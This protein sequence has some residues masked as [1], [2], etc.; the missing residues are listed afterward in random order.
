MGAGGATS[1][2]APSA[3]S[4]DAPDAGSPPDGA[5]A[6]PVRPVLRVA[7]ASPRIAASCAGA[8]SAA[9]STASSGMAAAPVVTA[10]ADAPG[11]PG[12]AEPTPASAVVARSAFGAVRPMPS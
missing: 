9:S 5:V 10:D 12:Q 4:G 7:A 11:S 6:L 1:G 8:V 2:P 3:L